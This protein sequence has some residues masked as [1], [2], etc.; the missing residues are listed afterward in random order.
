MRAANSALDTASDWVDTTASSQAPLIPR[1]NVGF[2]GLT[3]KAV[4]MV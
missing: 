2:S 3:V 1:S 4:K